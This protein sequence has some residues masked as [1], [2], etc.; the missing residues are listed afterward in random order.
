ME[1]ATGSRTG[2]WMAGCALAALLLASP[3][4]ALADEAGLKAALSD[5][6]SGLTQRGHDRLKA[7][8]ASNPPDDEI[9]RVVEKTSKSLWERMVRLGGEHKEMAEELQ[10]LARL[11][12]RVQQTID[13]ALRWLAAHQSADGLFE[14]DGYGRWCDGVERDAPEGL[15]VQGKGQYTLGV[16]ALAT[17]A[18]LGAGYSHLEAH[19]YAA[20]IAR[21]LAA[22]RI[23]Q[24][25]EGCI[26]VR[27]S[28]HYLYS[29]AA[30][31]KA[32]IEAYALSRDKDLVESAKQA[33]SFLVLAQ[34][35]GSG[36]RY[37]IK[38][39]D[40]D[41]SMTAWVAMAFEAAKKVNAIDVKAGKPPTFPY[42]P[43]V[44]EGI[45]SWF[46]RMTDPKT[47]EGGYQHRGTGSA[48]PTD[49]V[50]QFPAEKTDAVTAA[51]LCARLFLGMDPEKTPMVKMQ[52]ARLSNLPPKWSAT[53]G[54]NDFYYWRYGTH[55]MRQIG[56]DAWRG[57]R[58]SLLSAV[59]PRQR[60]DG[61][62][63]TTKGSWDP[64]DVW[65]F[66][67]GRVYATAMLAISLAEVCPVPHGRPSPPFGPRE[68]APAPGGAPAG[69]PGTKP[70]GAPGAAP[71]APGTPPGTP[72]AAPG[73]MEGGK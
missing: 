26:G 70:G 43:K 33:L 15:G 63:C 64:V 31:T 47:G 72:P 34:N 5:Y 36:W 25:V 69:P 38:P 73:G 18:F 30:A 51:G 61:D 40:S 35:E 54:S 57:W 39:G 23:A 62:I 42:D 28:G 8:L 7:Y 1:M 11:K 29:H 14:A 66:D 20:V 2:R 45:R 48:R 58:R 3:T 56:G 12:D 13:P 27:S 9:V 16:T 67:G 10:G 17:E 71:G 53:E 24:D 44:E 46:V 22:L 19:P 59:V 52:A 60:L 4:G 37:G 65:S 50:E 32:L 41:S 68:A 55:A 6:Q 49:L 21:S